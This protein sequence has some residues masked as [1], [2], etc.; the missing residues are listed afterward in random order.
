M[1]PLL[2]VNRHF[3]TEVPTLSHFDF[4]IVLH[5]YCIVIMLMSHYVSLLVLYSRVLHHLFGAVFW[6][7]KMTIMDP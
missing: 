1:V 6:N 5:H 3:S 2:N 4:P 7:K